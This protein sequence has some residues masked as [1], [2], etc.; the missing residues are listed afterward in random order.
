MLKERIAV[1]P[2]MLTYV[3]TGA[4][5]ADWPADWV[6]LAFQSADGAAPA[7]VAVSADA[8]LR[9]SPLVFA[10]D[11]GAWERLFEATPEPDTVWH[12]PSELRTVAAALCDCPLPEPA[13]A[14]L[15]LAKSIEL[16]CGIAAR[17]QADELIPA[18]G[19][20]ALS[21]GDAARILAARRLIDE[22]WGEK[23]TLDAIARACGLNRA[24][25][26][27]GFRLLF[28]TTVA[29]ALAANRLGGARRMLRE[30]DLPIASIGYACGYQNNASFTRAFSR[31]FGVAPKV[32]RRA[33]ACA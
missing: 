19:G 5:V 3:G 15:R 26:T 6:V 17:L 22:R 13:R 20:G 4:V 10:I 18:D 21:E 25:L 9:R 24:K 7:Q 31:H 28:D 32:A 1:S 27:R 11:P 2:E 12:L 23:L 33:E 16:F 30:T 29:D 14:T 8:D